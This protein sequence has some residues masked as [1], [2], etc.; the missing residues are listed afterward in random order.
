MTPYFPTSG[1]AADGSVLVRRGR[2][3]PFPRRRLVRVL[4]LLT[5]LILPF[6]RA[7]AT[8]VAFGPQ[9][10][11]SFGAENAS[12]VF[13]ADMDGDGDTDILSAS[14][15][16]DTIAWYENPSG[17]GSSFW[18]QRATPGWS[19]EAV[20]NQGSTTASNSTG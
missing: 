2:W 9:H 17:T 15:I 20:P 14:W 19:R 16:D 3:G 18:P 1:R 6:A 10:V 7:R 13:A 8:E 12:D 5:A 4:L 11:I